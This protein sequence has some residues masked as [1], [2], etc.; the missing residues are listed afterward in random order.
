M[1]STVKGKRLRRT[2]LQLAQLDAQLLEILRADHPQSIRHLFYR[3]TDPRLP[4]S[5]EKSDKGY[6]DVQ[7]RCTEL[8]RAGVL[9]YDWISDLSRRGYFVNT[10]HDAAQFL[11]K[12]SGQFRVDVW[13]DAGVT[14]ELW[15]ESRSIASVLMDVCR[16]YAVDLYP[17]GGFS[18]ITFVHEAA[19]HLNHTIPIDGEVVV[20]YVGDFDPAGVLI[21]MKLEEELRRHLSPDIYLTFVRLGITPEQISTYALPKKPRKQTD[22]RAKHVETAVEAEAMPAH[23][24]REIVVDAI[25]RH[26][27]PN[28]LVVAKE[29]ERT[30][31]EYLRGLAQLSRLEGV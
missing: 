13:R 31:Q 29:E 8:R 9:P 26:L 25:E 1:A 10:F 19:Q 17:C 14:V 15:V 20:Y 24:L 18:S 22:R 6:R 7:R 12:I 4:V 30:T 3:L 16:K 2:A 27:P 11:S 21:D 28:A 23:I 5:V